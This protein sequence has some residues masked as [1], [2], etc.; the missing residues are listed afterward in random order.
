[1]PPTALPIP[2]V[3]G[4]LLGVLLSAFGSTLIS[5]G[6]NVE[7]LSLIREVGA[8]QQEQRIFYRQPTW[9]AGFAVFIA[10]NVVNFLALAHAPAMSMLLP[11]LACSC[12][13]CSPCS[14]CPRGC[15]VRTDLYTKLS[16]RSATPAGWGG[17]GFMG[18]AYFK[19]RTLTLG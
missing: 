7:K 14:C 3:E 15:G 4:V 1:M 13:C 17:L 10:G 2:A 9:L 6:L 19:N 16:I 11:S 8:R 5:L 12:S 18:L